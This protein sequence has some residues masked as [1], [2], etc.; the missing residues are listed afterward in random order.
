MRKE[1]DES[2]CV[3][4]VVLPGKTYTNCLHSPLKKKGFA[5]VYLVFELGLT[6]VDDGAC[7]R[8]PQYVNEVIKTTRI[9]K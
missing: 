7:P 9:P 6:N 2:G 1:D 8:K 4:T 5:V 3:C